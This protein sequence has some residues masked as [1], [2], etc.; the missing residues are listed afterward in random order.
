ML[1]L[2]RLVAAKTS[3]SRNV[4]TLVSSARRLKGSRGH[5]TQYSIVGEANS[6][7]LNSLG[8]R[9]QSLNPDSTSAVVIQSR[10]A[11]TGR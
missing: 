9:L 5:R 11:C 4:R 6:K 3:H 7:E 8:H 10:E 2:E 1:P